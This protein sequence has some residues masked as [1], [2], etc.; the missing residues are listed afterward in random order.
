MGKR[1][2]KAKDLRRKPGT[3]R[4][5]KTIYVFCEGKVT[6]PAYIDGIKR[7]P[8]VRSNTAIRIETVSGLGQPLPLVKRAVDQKN[9]EAADIDEYWC[10]FDVEAPQPH[11]NLREAVALAENNDI[12]LAVSNPCFELWIALH[13]ADQFASLDTKQ[14]SKLCAAQ[15]GVKG[16]AICAEDIVPYRLEAIRRSLE[17][18]KRHRE[19]RRDFPADN[20]SSTMY[21]FLRSVDPDCRSK[22]NG[23]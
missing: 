14:A 22:R 15:T 7:L 5:R 11:A 2:T 6:E 20:P 13:H 3:R 8:S 21:Q 17:L 19:A 16:K 18:E 9:R 10:V 23:A 1:R 4:A 12:S